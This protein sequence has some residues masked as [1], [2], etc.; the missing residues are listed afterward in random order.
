MFAE[1]FSGYFVDFGETVVIGTS[2]GTAIVDA[3]VDEFSRVLASAVILT[4]AATEFPAAAAGQSAT[5][6][7]VSYTVRTVEPDGTGIVS[8]RVSKP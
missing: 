1:A 4:A 8:L 3:A 6:R 2:T 5:V 7:G